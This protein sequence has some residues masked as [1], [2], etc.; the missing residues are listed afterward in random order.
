MTDEKA[1][2]PAA[3]RNR[4]PI[5]EVLREVLPETGLV[6][7]IGS[8]TGQH[9]AHF[10][11][12]LTGLEWQPT[13]YDETRL[14]SIRAWVLESGVS[15]VRPVTRL[16]ARDEHWPVHR[17]DGIY[18]ANVIHI[19]PWSVAEGIF[20]GAERHLSDF[21]SLVLYGPFRFNGDWTADSNRA[22]DERLHVLNPEW[23]IR[24]VSDLQS[25]ATQQGLHLSQ[26]ID[27]PANNH[28][29]IFQR[30]ST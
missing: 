10:A 14:E 28:C 21:G 8:G 30:E 24:D 7:E 1:F 6:L 22:F 16:D 9:V 5:L 4:N 27:R 26:V 15:N 19:S 3:E 25:L 12:A 23:G 29:L 17:V 18:C 13:E 2:A 11:Q 20:R